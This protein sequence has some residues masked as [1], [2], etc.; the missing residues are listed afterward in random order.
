MKTKLLFMA[1]L[2][3]NAVSAQIIFQDNFSGY[4]ANNNLSGQGTWSNNTSNGGFGSCVGAVCSNAKVIN[5]SLAY[6]G[7]GTS[8]AAV[9]LKSDADGVGTLFTPVTSGSAYFAFLVNISNAA[10]TPNDFFRV[11]S[12]SSFNTT[13]R[14]FIKSMSASTFA[15][16]ISKGGTGNPTIYTTNTYAYGQDHLLV[17]KYTISGASNDDTVGLFVNPLLNAAEPATADA[18]TASGNDQASTIDRLGFRQ[19][20]TNIPVGKA[21]LITVSLSWGSILK[22]NNFQ[23]GAFAVDA[24][25]AKYG[26]LSFTSNESLGDCA[27]EIYAING[28]KLESKNI[29]LEN[30][31][32]TIQIHPLA[33]SGIYIINITNSNNNRYSKKIIIN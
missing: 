12:G 24:T 8:E 19:N 18:F 27:L 31:T 2:I 4:T 16:G 20:T 13:F 32:S 25:R 6:T 9:E 1:L 14:I 28:A 17:V 15:V 30:G 7:Y 3:A 33:V 11:C 23:A 21:G 22:T 26:E 5:Q 29:A 10:A